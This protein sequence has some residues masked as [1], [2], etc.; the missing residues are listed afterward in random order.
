MRKRKAGKHKSLFRAPAMLSRQ[1]PEGL[2]GWGE[3]TRQPILPY[4][5]IGQSAASMAR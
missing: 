3:R 5:F 1:E 4:G 2:A